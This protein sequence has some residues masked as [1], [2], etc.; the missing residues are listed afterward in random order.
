MADPTN[1][2]Q[3]DFGFPRVVR[4]EDAERAAL[5]AM[6]VSLGATKI[7]AERLM[8]ACPQHRIAT[9]AIIDFGRD[10]EE[11]LLW[12]IPM[13]AFIWVV[14]LAACHPAPERSIGPGP[15]EVGG[16]ILWREG[17]GVISSHEGSNVGRTRF[18][19][20]TDR[21]RNCANTM[22]RA[23][24]FRRDTNANEFL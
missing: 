20:S 17:F 10:G 13:R 22:P 6:L 5:Y 12:R 21:E 4:V 14:L 16:T 2:I 23:Q 7:R 3:H 18:A 1:V 19:L 8:Q 15:H 9:Q 24:I 11:T